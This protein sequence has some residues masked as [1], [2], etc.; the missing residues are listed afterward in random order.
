MPPL[1]YILLHPSA[2]ITEEELEVLKNWIQN[3][4]EEYQ[5]E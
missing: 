5:K 4:E 2:K 3:L 1:D